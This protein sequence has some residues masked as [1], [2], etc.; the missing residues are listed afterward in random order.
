MSLDYPNREDWLAYRTML[1]RPIRY[2]HVSG[3]GLAARLAMPAAVT[4]PAG[5]TYD[6]GRNKAKRAKRASTPPKKVES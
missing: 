1:V 6:I 4:I 3:Y 2:L 5:V